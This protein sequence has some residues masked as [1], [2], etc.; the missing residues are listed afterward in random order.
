[1]FEKILV[2]L[3]VLPETLSGTPKVSGKYCEGKNIHLALSLVPE[4]RAATCFNKCGPGSPQQFASWYTKNP[5][6][7]V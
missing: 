1:M 4:Q 2:L 7:K 5:R 6:L 3:W